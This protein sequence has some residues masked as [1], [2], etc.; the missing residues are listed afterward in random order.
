MLIVLPRECTTACGKRPRHFAHFVLF[1]FMYDAETNSL[2]SVTNA[3]RPAELIVKWIVFGWSSTPISHFF[4]SLPQ[5]MLEAKTLI[6]EV[7][8]S[9][10]RSDQ[11]VCLITIG[12]KCRITVVLFYPKLLMSRHFS[13][14][15]GRIT[16]LH[17]NTLLRIL[18]GWSN[19]QEYCMD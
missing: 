19:P 10:W 1:F 7:K 15:T 17:L 12:L 6:E 9:N 4:L 13:S 5:S 2:L 8:S 14:V 16:K 3:I 18:E 11:L